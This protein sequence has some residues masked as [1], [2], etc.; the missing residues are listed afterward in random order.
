MNSFLI[1]RLAPFFIFTIILEFGTL[2]IQA[3]VRY[4][5]VDWS[6]MPII[7]T[8]GILGLTSFVSFLYL[9]IPYVL[10]LWLVPA[11]FINTRGDKIIT[12]GGFAI[13]VYTVLS[14]E[15]ASIL[16]WERFGSSFND[17][18][19][20]YFRNPRGAVEQIVAEFP[21]E[22]YLLGILILTI[23]VVWSCRE[24]LFNTVPVPGWRKRLLDTLI[25]GGCCLLAFYNIKDEQRI[26]VNDNFANN[27]LAKEGTYSLFKTVW[28]QQHD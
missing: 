1:R 11:R 7:N 17:I 2:V 4:N 15:I 22:W 8:L 26:V 20:D 16:F 3:L 19:V 21:I 5:E 13:Y 18:A 10:Y 14:E 24:Y 27:E 25:Y 6:V 12:T 28:K 9:M 23:A